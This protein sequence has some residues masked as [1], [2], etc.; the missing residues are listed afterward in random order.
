MTVKF[1]IALDKMMGKTESYEIGDGISLGSLL[2][3]VM[4]NHTGFD[5]VTTEDRYLILL[6]GTVATLEDIVWQ[7]DVVTILQQMIGG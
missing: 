2:K 5:Y 1:F 7:G 3:V 6:N 4:E